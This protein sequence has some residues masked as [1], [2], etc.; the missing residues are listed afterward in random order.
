MYS[1]NSS[2]TSDKSTLILAHAM[3]ML[4]AWVLLVPIGIFTAAFTKRL[5]RTKWFHVHW[6]TQVCGVYERIY[7]VLLS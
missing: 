5:I 2:T 4:T 3:L 1:A 7:L 6:I